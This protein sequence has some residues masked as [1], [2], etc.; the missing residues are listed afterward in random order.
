MEATT[1]RDSGIIDRINEQYYFVK[2]DAEYEENIQFLGR[3]YSYIKTGDKQGYHEFCMLFDK[4]KSY[5]SL[6]F[7]N[8]Y[9]EHQETVVGY[10]N[11]DDFRKKI[12]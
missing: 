11:A 1:L 12:K 5:P 4:I 3:T 6:V 7:L 2:F 9:F 8:E 10:L